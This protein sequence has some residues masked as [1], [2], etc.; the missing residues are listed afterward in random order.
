MPGKKWRKGHRRPVMD[1]VHSVREYD[2]AVTLLR[3]L[4][5]ALPNQYQADECSV[6][7]RKGDRLRRR[8]RP[9]DAL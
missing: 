3:R 5:A 8:H 4:S 9:M 6:E 7:Q 2:L 1:G